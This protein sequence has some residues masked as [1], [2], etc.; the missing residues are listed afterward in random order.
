MRPVARSI[1]RTLFA[2]VAL[3]ACVAS[4]TEPSTTLEERWHMTGEQRT[5]VPTRFEGE[6]QWTA[7]RGDRLDGRADLL[8]Q[9]ASGQTVR[10]AGIATG[11]R[12]EGG[13]EFELQLESGTAR[14]VGTQQ[15]DTVRGTWLDDGTR[16]G[17]A[18]SAG[19]FRLERRR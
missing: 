1:R 4:P 14:Y 6:L 3:G 13:L 18:L 8:V 7:Q 10:R 2:C 15:G 9:D 19:S 5:P 17:G 12:L 11:R 16:G